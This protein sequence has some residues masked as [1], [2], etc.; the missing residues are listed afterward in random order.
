VRSDS[1]TQIDEDIMAYFDINK[2]AGTDTTIEA[3]TI[4]DRLVKFVAVRVTSIANRPGKS[5]EQLL[6]AQHRAEA[7][8]R[9]VDNLMR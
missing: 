4:F 8:R 1:N 9:A 2:G 7:A 5:P 6:A 3:R